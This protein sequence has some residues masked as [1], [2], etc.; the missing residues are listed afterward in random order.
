MKT[1][2]EL[3]GELD[4]GQYA[5]ATVDRNAVIAA[6]AGSGKT[7]VLAARY[8]Y[9]AVEKEIPVDEIV[10][11]TFTR[12]AAAEMYSR[13]YAT[14]RDLDH[15][16]AREAIADFH[17]A[18]IETIDS[19]CNSV[20]RAAC[21]RYGVSPDFAIDDDRA[22]DLADSLALPFFLERRASPAIRQLM[23][24]YSFAELPSRLL[25]ETAARH[26]PLSGPSDFSAAFS[27]QK[28]AVARRFGEV[29]D[30]IF[31]LLASMG[32]L[33]GG[34]GKAWTSV[35]ELLAGDFD[36]PE[37]GD[38]PAL[39][40]FGS[41]IAAIVGANKWGA[42]K[43]DACL[44]MKE[45][46]G[47]LKTLLEEYRSLVNFAANEPVIRE[48]LELVSDFAAL[49]GRKKREAGTLTFADSSRMAVDALAEDGELRAAYSSGIK[50]IM[51]DEFQDDNELQRDLLFLLAA[52]PSWKPRTP[53]AIP[54]AGEILGDR[55][56]FVGDEKQSIYRFR[57]AD[58]SVFRTL[59]RDLSGDGLPVLGTNYRSETPLIE[60]FNAIFPGV[61]LNPA[62]MAEGDFP[63]FEAAF[64][65]IGASRVT[66]GLDPGIT[67]V[68]LPESNFS[69]NDPGELTP[70]ESEAAEVA[71]RIR[72][73]R[74][75]GF[76]VRGEKDG[77]TRPLE[78]DDVAILFRTT[79]RQH[80]FEKHLRA[81]GIPC[82]T[83]SLTGLF[84][85]APIN[86]LY[87]LLRLAVYPRDLA[88]YA[89][90]LRSPLANLDDETVTLA[91]LAAAQPAGTPGIPGTA[92]SVEGGVMG[93][94]T[95]G[96]DLFPASVGELLG[97]DEKRRFL[98]AKELWDGTRRLADKIPAAELVTSIWYRAGYRYSV[99]R[100]PSL[101][102]FAELYD[103][104]FELARQ[105]DA[106][107]E[108]LAAFLDRVFALMQSGERVDDLDI[109]VE[110]T[111]GVR[112]MTVHKSKGLEFPVVFAVNADGTGRNDANADPVYASEEFGLTVNTGASEEAPEAGSNWFWNRV[113]EEE[114]QKADA[115]LRRLLYVAMTR[116]EVRL[117]V[118]ACLK[119]DSEPVD[120]PRTAGEL[121]NLLSRMLDRKEENA[122]GKPVRRRSFLELL[123][124]PLAGLLSGGE[125]PRLTIEE[126]LPRRHGDAAGGDD[127]TMPA[128]DF[129]ARFRDLARRVPAVSHPAPPRRRLSV[130]GF[131]SEAARAREAPSETS[132]ERAAVEAA[133]PA[134]GDDPLGRLL[135]RLGLTP[136]EFGTFAHRE[137]EARMTGLP[138]FMPAE[139]RGEAAAFAERFLSS[140]TGTLALAA[141]RRE[142]EYAFVTKWETD[143][144][145]LLLSG[146]MDLAFE[147]SGKLYVIDFKTDRVE[148]PEEHRLQLAVYRKAARELFGLPVETRLFYL[149][150]GRCVTVEE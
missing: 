37:T 104:F 35:T 8:V 56:F 84:A 70:A 110:K 150:T 46:Q 57:G 49:Y 112:L 40:A 20:V 79:G 106:R 63:L 65:P 120:A 24:R 39:S 138:A 133:A 136:A 114:R 2:K 128:S 107:G 18:R 13:I 144:E 140:E 66:P 111:G 75:G 22:R 64:S 91:L 83:E 146:Q 97:G 102:R 4:P 27:R 17:K 26:V 129:H 96:G 45:Y 72:A 90:F 139:I 25:A 123:A 143:G 81:R 76:L 145:T 53:G 62:L 125:I 3:L 32:T 42:T 147:S 115:E 109:P 54:G 99:V 43:N 89:M 10:A 85:D 30:G 82:Q 28:D 149:R 12:K 117:Y 15:P 98:A 100:D 34:S 131:A 9:L 80:L 61:F 11:L 73:L 60:A 77:E 119:V 134:P 5:A 126:A 124:P 113:R 103:Y 127:A 87:A 16:R 137:I 118:T 88:A 93:T 86:D 135:D 33:S 105:A 69:E 38:V 21:R 6:G 68:L 51:I 116:A 141:T 23:R 67:V 101:H 55:L 122:R 121:A 142:N 78:Y 50:A 58:V 44:A 130:T 59:E 92:G 1:L 71:A 52:P 108:T 19:F 74:D 48:T 132:A 94:G 29:L 41:K 148:N 31:S 36:R 14:L 95:S 7:R 47:E